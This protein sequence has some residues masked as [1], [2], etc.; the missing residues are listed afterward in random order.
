M[1]EAT[2]AKTETV[3][4]HSEQ[5]CGVEGCKRPYR[6]KGY[7]VTHYKLWR[8]GEVEG[9]KARYHICSKEACKKAAGRYGFCD[10]HRPASKTA[11]AAAA[12][13]A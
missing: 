7:C 11:P 10:E 3:T 4:P 9:H 1:S 6:A 5:K 13:S 12:P 8:R 2:E